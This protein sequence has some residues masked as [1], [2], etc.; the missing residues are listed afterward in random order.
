MYLFASIETNY[1]SKTRNRTLR[2]YYVQF[3]MQVGCVELL[4][5][6]EDHKAYLYL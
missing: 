3:Y 2:Q 5:V 4:A 6:S 1:A